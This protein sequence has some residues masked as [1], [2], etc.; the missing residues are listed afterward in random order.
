MMDF[1]SSPVVKI[2]PSNAGAVGSIPGCRAKIPHVSWPQNQNIKQKP[3]GNKFN[4]G[5][6]IGPHQIKVFKKANITFIRHIY[7]T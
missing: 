1:P 7:H 5:F 6:K 3:Y 2:L 4:K